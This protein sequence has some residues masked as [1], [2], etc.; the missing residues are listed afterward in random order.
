MPFILLKLLNYQWLKIIKEKNVRIYPIIKT[1]PAC[2][3][4]NR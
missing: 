2:S 4:S 3:V 1:D